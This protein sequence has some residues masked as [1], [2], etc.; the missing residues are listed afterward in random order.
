MA[1]DVAKHLDRAK[2][3]LEKNKLQ[4]AIEAY[5]T[6]L[7][8][9][10]NH[11]EAMQAL[12]DLHVRL[13]EPERAAPYYGLLFDRLTDP[14]EE[15]KAMALYA[16]FVKPYQPPPE[17]MARYGLLLQKHHKVEEAIEQY[18]AAAE[19][20]AARHHEQEALA[21]WERVAELDP[22]NPAR[23]FALGEFGERL[24]NTAVASR[25]FL[26]AGQLALAAGELDRALE[27][28]AR[29][30][31]LAPGE[32]SVA[33]LYASARLRQGE[34]AA[35]VE[36]LTPFA[37]TESDPGFLETF[38]EALMLA[39]QLDRARVVLEHF[40]KERED[41]FSKLFELA[42]RFA[43]AKQDDQAVQLLAQ[44]KKRMFD[45]RHQ[46]EFAAQFDRVAEAN[47]S[48]I[49]LT[50]SWGALYSE[51]NR[52]AKYFDVLVRLFDLYLEAGNLTGACE[53]LD[54][55]VDIDPYGFRNQ[56]R[57]ERL[58]GRADPAYLRGVVVRLGRA[59]TQGLQAPIDLSLGENGG[60]PL[61]EEG[62]VQQA[63]DDLLVQA[64]IFLQYSLQAKAVERLQKIAEMFPGEEEHN[65]RLHNLYEQAQWWPAGSQHK[66]EGAAASASSPTGRT[67]TYSPETLRDLAK[68]SEINHNVYRQ[69][70]PR[71]VLSVAVN[72]VG[73]YLHATRCL[74]VVGPPG[75]PPQMASE[76]CA[77]G[78]QASPGSQIVHLLAQLDRAAPD[79]LGGLPL[80]AAAAP[81]LR[82]MGLEAVLGVQLIDKDTQTPV[83]VL[84]AGHA[85]AHNWKPNETY[86]LQAVGDQ[87]LLSVNHTRLRT[88]VRTLAVADE[89]TGLLSRSS[90][91]DCL[92]GETTR[93]KTQGTPLS[94]AILQIDRGPELLRQQGEGMVER[95]M[96]QLARVVQPVVRQ[97]DLAVKYTAWALAFILP[98]TTLAGARSLAEK[99]RGVA[100]G[101]RPPWDGAPLTVSASI[102]EAIARPDYDSEDIVTDLIN[103]AEAGLEEARRKGG[104]TVVSPVILGR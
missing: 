41:S 46:S 99:L 34:A 60:E 85:A 74:A 1:V 94:L 53:T 91:Q 69:P 90:Y 62:R 71:L 37:A 3:Y 25:G 13:N 31:R 93:A 79:S 45:A 17:R 80:E 11:R 81:V 100:T 86:F 103:R 42:D 40:Y 5:Q 23:H 48:S 7:E 78:V 16:R 27:L 70:T 28:F 73:T 36:L 97:N 82:E 57:I 54:R 67:G 66:P 32:R 2:R 12:G 8:A 83:G 39:G 75:Q 22:D 88:L 20:F 104:N 15:T 4:D 49:P 59:A 47:P 89:K 63:L 55:L 43:K 35:A 98:D 52:E 51:L 64:E 10:P 14:R 50:E 18:T 84:L 24:G 65:E 72:E 76:F 68:I 96:E 26:R 58:Q 102:A 29:A 87:M 61:T 9:S 19:Q 56:Q 30:H 38:G 21:C 33:M 95:H 92:L 77:P 6:V 101:V 44:I